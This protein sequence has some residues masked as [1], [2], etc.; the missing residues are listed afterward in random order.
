[1][2]LT[3]ISN[4]LELGEIIENFIQDG[5]GSSYIPLPDVLK[6]KK[7]IINVKNDDEHCLRYTLRAALFPTSDHPQRIIS[8]PKEDG[9][10]F[11]VIEMPTPVSQ[12]SKVECLNNLAI[13]VYGWENNKVI[14]HRI[15]NQPSDVK[16]INTLIIQH[17]VEDDEK[18][19][20]V[21]I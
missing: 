6:N 17:C 10:N 4:F 13:N 20:Y 14:I 5:S 2:K 12:I 7:A 3:L 11:D 1:M 16:R 19:H 8:Y 15:S 21:L 18:S 9:L